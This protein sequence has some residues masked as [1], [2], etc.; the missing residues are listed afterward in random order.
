M[1]PDAPLLLG[2]D[3]GTSGPKVALFEA[4]GPSLGSQFEPTALML[5]EGGGAE[6]SPDDWWRAIVTATRRLLLRFPQAAARVVGVGCT[7][8]WSGTV[9]V[10]AQGQVIGNAI[11]WMDSRGAPLVRQTMAGFPTVQGY[12]AAK[13][14]RSLRLTGGVPG[15]SGKDS[16]A[17][18]LFLRQ[19]RPDL[20]RRA[21]RFL[22]PK[23]YLNFRLTGRQAASF[24]SIALHWVTDNRDPNAVRYHDGLLRTFGLR[25][26]QLPELGPAIQVLGPLT[27]QTARELGV[28]Q[29]AQVVLGS[30]DVQS[31]AVGSGATG[32]Y[33]AHLYIGTSSWLTCH[34]P[35]KKTDVVNNMATLVSAIP[36]RYLIG[37]TQECAGVCLSYLRDKLFW[38]QDTLDPRPPPDDAYQRFDRLVE[39]TLPD[40]DAVLFT[41]WLY[42]ERTPVEDPLI[43][44]GFHNLS[45]STRREHL[46]R[47]VYEGV[48]LNTRWLHQ[49]VR[50]FV[51]RDFEAINLIGGG[52]RSAAWCQLH[53]DVLGVPIRQVENPVEANA[54]GAAILVGVGLGLT[55][56]AQVPG[57]VPIA[58]TFTPD[59]ALRAHYDHRFLQFVRLYRANRGIHARLNRRG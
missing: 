57:Q 34:L 22:E 8:Q 43:R 29:S 11:I 48:A 7:A 21:V 40:Q 45:L 47:A 54:R 53:A 49:A 12:G 28:P 25:R 35:G 52:A 23:D 27:A 46:V 15:L 3:L 24:D 39:S 31:A 5:S 44:G 20:Y 32:D 36:G 2:I 19:H 58:R 59:P 55:T 6:Q 4:G 17:H 41:P 14:W 9:A 18:I 50:G 1:A 33:Q 13:L 42:G 38:P 37:N 10:D 16:L 26:D 51:G 56:F 30:A